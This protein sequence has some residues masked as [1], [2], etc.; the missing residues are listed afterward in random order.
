MWATKQDTADYVIYGQKSKHGQ[1][2]KKLHE[3]HQHAHN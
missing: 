3:E 2:M 1:K